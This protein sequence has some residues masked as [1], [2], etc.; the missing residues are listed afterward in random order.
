MKD[1]IND[2]KSSAAFLASM[3]IFGTVGVARRFIPLP[4][5]VLAFTRGI[6]GGLFLMAFVK[7][8]KKDAG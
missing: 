7:L 2:R 6:L 5:A 8:R 4:S 3:L 1:S